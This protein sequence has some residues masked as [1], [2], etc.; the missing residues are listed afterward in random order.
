MKKVTIVITFI[1]IAA[2]INSQLL[3]AQGNVSARIEPK[4][5]TSKPGEEVE[6][7]LYV[8][9]RGNSKIEVTGIRLYV[10]SET[11]FY[12]PI[13]A[14]LGEYKIPF[15]EPVE[16]DPGQEK[17]IKKIIEIPNIPLAGNFDI[18]VLV[19]T[20]GGNAET[21]LKVNLG[22]TVVSVGTLILLLLVTIGI[23]YGIF[24]YVKGKVSKEGRF[25][26]KLSRIDALLEERYRVTE[27]RR[28][29]DKRRSEGKI[30]E[31][32]YQKL[33]E[34]YESNLSRI[35]TELERFI[36]ELEKEVTTLKEEINRLKEEVRVIKAR[37]EV[38]ELSKGAGK[39]QLKEREKLLKKLEK[40]LSEAEHRLERLK[41]K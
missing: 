40:R 33:K 1:L 25:R 8:Y 4:I 15:D 38:G 26:R 20:T 36:P 6:I 22:Y 24:L 16:V 10:T 14:H 32:E 19:E 34:E 28:K 12:L 31:V 18:R 23:L 21:E 35:Q 27:L 7:T 2:L 5:L 39:S 29:L 37:M 9:N 13:R 3:S 41:G 30:G 17:P 11:L